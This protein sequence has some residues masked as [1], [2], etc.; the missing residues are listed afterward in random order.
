[1]SRDVTIVRSR[2]ATALL[3]AMLL[4][5]AALAQNATPATTTDDAKGAE[6]DRVVVT[7]S[8]IPQTSKE[9]STP[10]SI[11]SAEDIKA[12]GFTSVSD[13]LQ[14]SSY[15][16]GGVQ[17]GQTSAGFTQGAETMSLF[18]LSVGY[19]KYLIDGRPMADYPALYNGS[20]TFNNISG[21]PIDL[22]E[23]IEILPGGQSSLYGSDAIAG[24]VNIILKKKLDAPV[25]S[26]RVGGYTDGGGDGYRVSGATTFSGAGDR[27][28]LLVGAQ[29]EKRNPI[30]AYDRD[31]TKQYNPN[32]TTPALASRDF[33][34]YGYRNIGTA[35]F[36]DYGYVFL[37]P[38]NCANTT[39]LFGG[40][41][42]L[43]TRPGYG[44][45]CGSLYTPG[46]R[47]LLN[48]KEAAQGYAHATYD[49]S[50]DHQLYADVLYSHENVNYNI[51]AGYT[52]WGTGVKWGYFYD[53]NVDGLV[54]LQRGFAPEDFGPGGYKNTMSRDTSNSWMTTVGARGALG[55]SGWDYDAFLSGT[56]Y[57]LNERQW[58]RLA[59]PINDWFEQNILG[60]QQGLDPYYG[61]YPV[62][63][64]N[65]ARFY[66]PLTAAEIASFSDFTNS[67]SRT[68][69]SM[70]R[71]QLTNS[72]LF[73]LPGGD[74]G[75]AL[76]VEGGH[77]TWDYNPDP[78]LLD[79][80]IWGTTSVSGGGARNRYAAIG[81]LRL[82]VFKPL[83]LSLSSR[84]DKFDPDGA[85]TV[86]KATYSLGFEYR[87]VESLLFRGKYGTAF[88]APTLADQFQ[89][90]SGYYS[91][92]TDYYACQ[93][94]GF[95]PAEIDNC[96]ARYTSVQYFGTTSGSLDLR[97]MNADVWSGGVVWAPTAKFSV[98]ADVHHWAIK[99]EVGQQNANGLALREMY[100]RTGTAGYDINSPVCQDAISKITRNGAGTITDIY[101]P[102]VNEALE[103]LTA[104][105]LNASY[106]IDVGSFG[107]LLFRGSYTNNLK[108]EYTQFTGDEAIDLL[109]RPGWSTDPKSKANGSVTWSNG[110]WGTTLYANRIGHTPNY[111]AQVDDNYDAATAGKL[112]PF[113][114]YNLSVDYQVM[115][116]LSLSLMVNNL[117]NTMPPKDPTY[118]GSTGE[119]Y[120]SAQYSPYGRAVYL[121]ARY[122]FGKK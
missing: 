68:S 118:P 99:D 3:A 93:Q 58:A 8:L 45:Y 95:T 64:P 102:K 36:D 30:W 105:T 56:R 11:I 40:T 76:A 48:G 2:L 92:V 81:E 65:Y 96:P 25:I 106:R 5:T 82:P 37:D 120:N 94:R 27:F 14:Q 77:Q 41:E 61:A 24:V 19:T 55:Q 34:E 69:D 17:G 107:N 1:M 54:N 91:F 43:N 12:R 7:G 111:R 103:V 21:I 79:G 121:E 115:P 26:A 75:I 119:P 80:E 35:G 57:E 23:R 28:N 6:L 71:A 117:F 22:V 39:A 60:P 109:R 100:C 42:G 59:D 104:L 63:S 16:T 4:P 122:Q 32:G 33:L 15:S 52:W 113:T 67:K 74:A 85:E 50:A 89:G 62:F 86:S 110:D 20:D 83:T 66:S 46:Y 90:E 98:G 9:T 44:Q 114:L 10:V 108:H 31:I 88:K 101:T 38:N 70:A 49:L 116:Q 112:D 51:G 73:A 18:G 97:P 29:Y 87:P 53:P 84:Y 72:A 13:A 47:T 78:R